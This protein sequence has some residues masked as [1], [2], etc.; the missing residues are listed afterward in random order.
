MAALEKPRLRSRDP[1][2]LRKH[3]IHDD[4]NDEDYV[5]DPPEKKPKIEVPEP[6]PSL[7][8]N[9]KPT[10]PWKQKKNPVPWAPQARNISPWMELTFRT[11]QLPSAD[12]GANTC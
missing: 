5:Y 9:V 3:F 2:N 4:V 10:K 12:A 1:K 6:T 7:P 8:E 11:Q